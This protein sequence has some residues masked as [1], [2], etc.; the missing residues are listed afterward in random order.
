ME[1]EKNEGDYRF[2]HAMIREYS[3]EI[4]MTKGSFVV[5]VSLQNTFRKLYDITLDQINQ[6]SIIVLLQKIYAYSSGFINYFLMSFLIM[7][8]KATYNAQK[9]S[10]VSSTTI[11]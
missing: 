10:L 5:I 2:Q 4:L 7:Y 9:I 3:K 8:N 6:E 1:R 11:F